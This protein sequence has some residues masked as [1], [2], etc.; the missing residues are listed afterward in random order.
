MSNYTTTK[1][2]GTLGVDA[3][4]MMS[5]RKSYFH[6]SYS[7]CMSAM[8]VRKRPAIGCASKCGK[9]VTLLNPLLFAFRISFL[10]IYRVKHYDYMGN[11]QIRRHIGDANLAGQN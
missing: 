5:F 10:L 1:L 7:R 11:G 9:M 4:I 3:S 2:Y 6:V 8:L